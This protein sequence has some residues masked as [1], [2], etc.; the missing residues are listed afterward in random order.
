MYPFD[1]FN[2]SKSTRKRERQSRGDREGIG[3]ACPVCSLLFFPNTLDRQDKGIRDALPNPSIHSSFFSFLNACYVGVR[4]RAGPIA[5][6]SLF[7]SRSMQ[8]SQFPFLT[9]RQDW[10]RKKL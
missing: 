9:G 1:A 4:M 2:R 5:V 10:R 7:I 8:F 6:S 3:G